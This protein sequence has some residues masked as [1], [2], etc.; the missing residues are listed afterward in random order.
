MGS[1]AHRITE[2]RAAARGLVFATKGRV[3]AAK[4]ILLSNVLG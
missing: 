2:R 4:A 1:L 3:A